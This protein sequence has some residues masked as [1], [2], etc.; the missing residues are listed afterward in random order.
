MFQKI[1][2][3]KELQVSESKKYENLS[4][5]SLPSANYRLVEKNLTNLWKSVA[6]GQ[7]AKN[8][9]T[10]VSILNLVVFA[11]EE[12]I[13]EKTDLLVDA[14]TGHPPLR[15][16]FIQIDKKVHRDYLDASVSVSCR[17][18]SEGE[19]QLCC[20]KITLSAGGK[21]VEK[22]SHGLLPLL[23][24]DLP[25]FLF[26]P[27]DLTMDSENFHRLVE[28][29]NRV[30]IDSADFHVPSKVIVPLSHWVKKN[31]SNATL[32]DINWARLTP[33]REWVAEFFDPLPNRRYLP[34]INRVVVEIN[35]EKDFSTPYLLLGWLSSVLNWKLVDKKEGR[36]LFKKM[37]EGTLVD[38]KI[39]L[40]PSGQR[41]SMLVGLMLSSESPAM[42]LHISFMQEQAC[43]SWM[44]ATEGNENKCQEL[45][46]KIPDEAGLFSAELQILKRDRVYEDS[47]AQAASLCRD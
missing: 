33:W 38:A 1:L 25:V 12:S 19:K 11:Q 4:A 3:E 29:C 30:V 13:R 27:G 15:A 23:E 46:L 40:L 24:P 2:K 39:K 31:S 22:I 32:S 35:G 9:I 37:Q 7:G 43:V 41:K 42:T 47:L 28:V 6:E 10:R 14:I 26:W 45:S 44:S 8:A 36:F 21:G 17:L 16:I 5:E 20:E 18:P 34:A